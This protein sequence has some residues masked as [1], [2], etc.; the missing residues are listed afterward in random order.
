MLPRSLPAPDA[1]GSLR[2]IAG[3]AGARRSG[4]AARTMHGEASDSPADIDPSAT[5]PLIPARDVRRFCRDY[6]A[7]QTIFNA[8]D[9][10][11]CMFI[12]LAGAVRIVRTVGG[13]G[14]G[15]DSERE[16]VL[17]ELGPGEFFGEMALVDNSTRMA[18]AV[19]VTGTRL[20]E[21]DRARFVYLVGQQ[22]AFALTVMRVLAQ[23]L[24]RAQAPQS[25]APNAP[26]VSGASTAP[27]A[28][29]EEQ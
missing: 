26:D 6:A 10:G 7:G 15:S 23:R 4:G 27:S 28:P 18:S 13:S 11:N 16:D 2:L 19:A 1:R 8:G 22:P 5:A 17:A 29:Q 14:S 21:I 20:A 12:V 24:A 3:S 9:R 25:A